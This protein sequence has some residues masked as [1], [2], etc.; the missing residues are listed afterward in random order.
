MSQVVCGEVFVWTEGFPDHYTLL[1]LILMVP[2]V[3]LHSW[4]GSVI[5]DAIGGK[6]GLPHHLCCSLEGYLWVCYVSLP[7]TA[8]KDITTTIHSFLGI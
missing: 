3:D 2:W 5:Y 7:P 6:P 1:L 4:Y 8:E